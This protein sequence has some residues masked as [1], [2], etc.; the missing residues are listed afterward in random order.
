[1]TVLGCNFET[2]QNTVTFMS[3]FPGLYNDLIL[4]WSCCV[5]FFQILLNIN[6]IIGYY[7]F[8]II[9]LS[10]KIYRQKIP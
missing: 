1:M 7:E 8:L 6:V 2:Q 5:F 10:T 4:K 9:R 3:N